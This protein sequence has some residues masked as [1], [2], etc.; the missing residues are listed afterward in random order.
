MLFN[1]LLPL[2]K[3]QIQPFNESA[4]ETN[5]FKIKYCDLFRNFNDKKIK[6]CFAFDA[7]AYVQWKLKDGRFR[8]RLAAAK[9]RVSPLKELTIPRL[10]LQA[11]VIASRLGSNIVEELRF[12]FER[13]RYF[14]DSLVTLS[15]IKSESRS[16]K[17]FVSCPV[18]EIQ[19]K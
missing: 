19:S 2:L 17:P 13:I 7:C 11:A 10:K 15:W 14:S 12:K 18:G 8:V 16:F 1:S 9:S 5:E 3:P 4:R 6:T